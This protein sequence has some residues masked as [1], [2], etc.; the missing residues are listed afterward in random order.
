MIPKLSPAAFACALG[1][2][3]AAA[4][5]SYAQDGTISGLPAEAQA[6]APADVIDGR[7][8]P[9]HRFRNATVASAGV[10]LRNRR[11]GAIELGG[12]PDGA[13]IKKAFLYWNMITSGEP[14]TDADKMDIQRLGP[15]NNPSDTVTGAM[16]GEGDSPCWGGDRNV[17]YRAELPRRLVNGN[18]TYLVTVPANVPGITDGRGSWEGNTLPAY[19]GASLVVVAE[20]VGNVLVYEAPLSGTEFRSSLKYRLFVPGKFRRAGSKFIHMIHSDGQAGTATYTDSADVAGEITV[21]NGE[22][23]SGK[24]S[25]GHD[26]D[27]NGATGGRVHQL[28]DNAIRRLSGSDEIRSVRM[29]HVTGNDCLVTVADVL[30]LR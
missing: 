21:A 10:G 29:K 23:I 20:G 13:R 17:V 25:Q 27:W 12:L 16:I 15:G 18:G 11:T 14:P 7:I 4:T 3:L 26:S 9:E 24:R 28:W 1:L 30:D 19:N 22:R 2:G 8:K 6:N 5:A